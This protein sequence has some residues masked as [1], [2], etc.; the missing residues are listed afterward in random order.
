V[1]SKLILVKRRSFLKQKGCSLVWA[2]IVKGKF[3]VCYYLSI[4]RER[5]G[6]GGRKCLCWL[7]TFLS[8][9]GKIHQTLWIFLKLTSQQFDMICLLRN[10]DGVVAT[11]IRQKFFVFFLFSFLFFFFWSEVF[12][13]FS[14]RILHL[15]I[16][17]AFRFWS[18]LLFPR[19]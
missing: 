3:T 16:I 13:C 14:A 17:T 8:K 6:E 1:T 7:Q 19:F 11:V 2:K 15:H 18:W 5:G 10:L 12:I 4:T 9:K